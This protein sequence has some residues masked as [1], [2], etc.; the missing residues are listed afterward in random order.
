[1]SKVVPEAKKRIVIECRKYPD[2]EQ[3]FCRIWIDKAAFANVDF[4]EELKSTE[5]FM[6]K[7]KHGIP[8]ITIGTEFS[9][10]VHFD[11]RSYIADDLDKKKV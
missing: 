3:P 4:R 8:D 2:E 6:K 9:Q 10:G 1:M 11:W 5:E 7:F